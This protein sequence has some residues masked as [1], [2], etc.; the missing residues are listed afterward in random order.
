V[1]RQGGITICNNLII[2]SQKVE[3]GWPGQLDAV[4]ESCDFRTNW[5]E[6]SDHTETARLSNPPMAE[7]RQAIALHSRDSASPDFLRPEPGS[8]IATSGAGGEF[9][10]YIGALAPTAGPPR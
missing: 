1:A 10:T 9:P 8:A 5:W 3:W 2:D 4:A 6:P 7:L